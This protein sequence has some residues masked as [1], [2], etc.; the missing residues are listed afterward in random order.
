[1]GGG[2]QV[3][4][5]EGGGVHPRTWLRPEETK[6]KLNERQNMVVINCREFSIL[7]SGSGTI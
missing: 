2:G 4:L 7:P 5:G 3:P 6:A 1:M